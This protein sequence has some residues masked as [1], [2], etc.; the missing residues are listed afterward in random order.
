MELNFEKQI[1]ALLPRLSRRP[2]RRRLRVYAEAL[3]M[4]FE[5]INPSGRPVPAS[6]KHEL[7]K[8]GIRMRWKPGAMVARGP[9]TYLELRLMLHAHV[10]RNTPV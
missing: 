7:A 2:N 5:L 1:S 8:D 4:N 10:G 6:Q 3:N 9:V